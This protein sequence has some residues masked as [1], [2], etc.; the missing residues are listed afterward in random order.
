MATI[1][2]YNKFLLTQMNGGNDTTGTSTAGAAR[3]VDFDTDTIKVMLVTNTYVPSATGH[4]AKNSVTN[5][6]TGT[7]YTAGG[8]TL[9]TPTVVDTTGTIT[10]DAADT[11][12]TQNA[13][14]FSNARHA[15]IY[16]DTGTPGTSTLIG[17]V[18][19]GADKGNVAGDL[20]LQ[21]NASGIVTWA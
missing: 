9:G 8:A 15:I 2:K 21:W 3:V 10:F 5:E 12:W 11:T 17:W 4:A 19:F 20:T 1:L 14:G 18:D 7:G 13:A 6:V 16:K